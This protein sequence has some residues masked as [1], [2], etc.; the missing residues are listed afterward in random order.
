MVDTAP[1]SVTE[2][3]VFI[4]QP[5]DNVVAGSQ[6]TLA[7]ALEDG[8]GKVDTS[9][10]GSVSLSDTYSTSYPYIAILNGNLTVN[11]VA[12]VATFSGISQSYNTSEVYSGFPDTFYARSDRLPTGVSNAF[13]L[14]LDRL[15]FT[16][17]PPSSVSAGATFSVVVSAEDSLGN[18]DTSFDG[19]IT[20]VDQ[21]SFIYSGS[22]FNG[23]LA[24]NAVAGVAIFSNLSQS[25]LTA[26]TYTGSADFL[27]AQTGTIISYS[28]PFTVV[29]VATN[30]RFVQIPQDT[31]GDGYAVVNAPLSVQVQALNADGNVDTTFNGNIRL[32]LNVNPV[33]SV[34]IGGATTVAA[35]NGVASFTDLT[36]NAIGVGYTLTAAGDG[37]ATSGAFTVTDQ[38]VFIH[39]PPSTVAA[40]I[41]SA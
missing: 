18:V 5:P 16:T 4:T 31:N 21:Y 26:S 13:N 27:I 11:A 22:S 36:I 10:T 38:L 25:L 32:S 6:I 41:L 20:I 3:L 35:I 29:A 7:V 15:I 12:G 9:F 37:T 2:R 30:L 17:Q 28:S 40:G 34:A 8:L 33:G 1:F 14:T 19:N 23:T 24:V 39:Q